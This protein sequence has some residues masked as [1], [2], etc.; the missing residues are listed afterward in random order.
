MEQPC[1][2]QG[3]SGRRNIQHLGT[4]ARETGV[5]SAEYVADDRA[6]QHED[7]NNNNSDQNKN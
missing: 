4:D 6:E 2:R 7:R 5:E 3:C 1:L